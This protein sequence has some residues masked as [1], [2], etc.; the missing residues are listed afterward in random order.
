MIY[1]Y[2]N[3]CRLDFPPLSQV[4]S[5]LPR[6]ASELIEPLIWFLS[7]LDFMLTQLLQNDRKVG[8]VGGAARKVADP[9]FCTMVIHCLPLFSG[10]GSKP[11]GFQLPSS[12]YITRKVQERFL[13]TD[14]HY[15]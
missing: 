3:L 8:S 9:F 10:L 12:C 7:G 11:V 15:S 14:H 4:W 13:R 1:I 2:S 5:S 6:T